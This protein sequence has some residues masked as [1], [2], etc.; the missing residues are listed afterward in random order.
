MHK[1]GKYM[2][3]RWTK[4]FPDHITK[5]YSRSTAQTCTVHATT[6]HLCSCCTVTQTTAWLNQLCSVNQQLL[7]S[8]PPSPAG[9]PVSQ[10]A[11]TRCCGVTPCCQ[12]ATHCRQS[13]RH[14]RACRAPADA[15][16]VQ[17]RS[18]NCVPC[19]SGRNM[20][21]LAAKCSCI[22]WPSRYE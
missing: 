16:R 13:W 3:Q 10:W 12:A 22:P 9:P 5:N 19:N 2:M 7:L 4:T 6:E 11:L 14:Q 18:I 8:V 1:I 17:C 21:Q 20:L 15:D